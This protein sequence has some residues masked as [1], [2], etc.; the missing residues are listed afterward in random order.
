MSLPNQAVHPL[1]VGPV[2]GAPRGRSSDHVY[3]AATN[4]LKLGGSLVATVTIALV[5][6][7]VLLPRYLGPEQ[8]GA[9]SFA[10]SFTTGLFVVLF[11]GVDVYIQREIP[12]RPGHASDFHGGLLALR[13]L[14]VPL[15]L[16][17]GAL[18]LRATGQAT[19]TSLVLLFG[20][21]QVLVR[22]N[23]T[24]AA[25]LRANGT[26]D[27]LSAQTVV[28][29]LV[30]GAGMVAAA[31]C[32]L[33]LH[34]IALAYL[35]PEALKTVALSVLTRRHLK[36]ALRW[37][38]AA[39]RSVL[40]ASL[41][42]FI[43]SVA[44]VV[45]SNVD[46]FILMTV[47]RSEAEVG[48]YSAAANLSNLALLL[49]PVV[50]WVMLP[51][52]SRAYADSRDEFLA[53]VRHGLELVLVVAIPLSLA[54]GL[55]AEVWIR[56]PGK[57]YAPGLVSLH[58]LAPLQTL[59]YV[60]IV[61]AQALIVLRRSWTVTAISVFG[62]L[63]CPV[64]N[65][66]LVGPARALLDAAPGHASAATAGAKLLTEA[67]VCVGMTWALGRTLFD[68]RLRSTVLRN[69]ACCVLTIGVH[70]ALARMGLL[71]VAVDALVYVVLALAFRVIPF[72]D[73]AREIRRRRAG[74]SPAHAR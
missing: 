11:F 72:A 74:S 60:N 13:L 45:Y 9:L 4:A 31:A 27:G 33:G 5:A 62:M 26:V 65:L 37:D 30:W 58:L 7:V 20:L 15:L 14:C 21:W 57:D 44:I 73:L 38:P 54:L 17:A 42:F 28:A 16:G 12:V 18:V 3:Q 46:R 52:F 53:T 19:L 64:L 56:I 6:R 50:T 59:T 48:W 1:L 24:L 61:T 47:T 22:H 10:E 8:F 32:G 2:D 39:L 34:A 49:S 36:L 67:A 71:R 25:M 55:G 23:E 43:N 70:F 35:L 63:L 40:A 41:P 69:A 51:L 66:S 29:K 68:A